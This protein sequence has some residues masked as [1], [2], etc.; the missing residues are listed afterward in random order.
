MRQMITESLL[1]SVAA[2]GLG[3]AVSS[4]IVRAIA[5]IAPA[6]THG[7]HELRLDTVVLGFTIAISVV[8]GILFGVTPAMHASGQRLEDALRHTSRSLVGGSTRIRGILVVV[9]VALSVVLLVGSGL[10]IRSL[11]ALLAVDPGFQLRHLLKMRLTLPE[12]KY[13]EAQTT[14]FNDKLLGL[15]RSLPGVEAASLAHGVPMQDISFT[16]Y[17]V[18]GVEIKAGSEPKAMIS[19]VSDHYFEILGVKLLRGRTFAPA[20]IGAPAKPTPIIVNAAFSRATILFA[21]IDLV[22]S[23][24]TTWSSDLA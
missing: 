19:L 13:S 21:K 10:M 24:N 2:A 1:L 14:V 8:T 22:A 6:D 15:V 11:T 7:M 5:A 3:L 17:R 9:E 18:E 23:I 4:L 12:S 16:S 20:D